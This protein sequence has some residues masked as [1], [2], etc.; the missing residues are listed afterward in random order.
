MPHANTKPLA[1]KK[2]FQQ[3]TRPRVPRRPMDGL[4][5]PIRKKIGSKKPKKQ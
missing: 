4:G 2:W 5:K 3:K 1:R